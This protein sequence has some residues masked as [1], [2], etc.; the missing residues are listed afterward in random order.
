MRLSTTA[1]VT[2]GLVLG[3]A[4][5]IALGAG[6]DETAA[7]IVR[8]V[9]PIGTLWVNAIRM[10]VVPLVVPL[11]IVGVAG[12]GDARSAGRLG[13]RAFLFFLALLIIAATFTALVA[14]SLYRYLELDPAATAALRA[15]AQVNLPAAEELTFRSWLLSIVPVN[16]FRALADGALLAIVF[17]TLTYA[18]ALT[19]VSADVRDSQVRFFRGVS[20]VIFVV[21]RWV[22]A[23]APVGI[24]ALALVLG[25]RLGASVVG[26]IGFYVAMTIGLHAFLAIFLYL[27][28]VVGGRV[29]LPAF[30][31]AVLPAQLV[32][33]ST[34]SSLA[35]LPAL[36]QGARQLGLSPAVTG[37]VLPFAVS[38]FKLTSPVYWMIGALFV[39]EL[40]G[41]Q[42]GA[43]QIA[44]VAAGAV[45]LNASSPG[46]P[47]GGLL[48][49]AP[50]YA[51]VGL[52][53]EGLG[54]LIA[55]DTVPDSF[56]TPFNV[57]ADLAVAAVLNRHHP[58]EAA[59]PN[60]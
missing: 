41:M 60:A 24:F 14:P 5:G 10:T 51:A 1:A 17:F 57:T 50:L 2:I 49:Q 36:I 7:G 13:I 11:L 29:S 56:K 25:S 35:S 20:D 38:I 45:V 39:A 43:A 54:I 8:F 55:V 42:L 30:A 53:V 18:F 19:R 4:A 46:I 3:L 12:A 26:A 33:A 6:P 21:V 44:T 59:A 27:L 34:R 16:P 52:P 58:T 15:T 28:A 47:S 23:L 40:Y 37:F 9:E 31:R 22:L 48:I 32:A